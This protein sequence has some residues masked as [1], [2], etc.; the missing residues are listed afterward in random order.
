M[1]RDGSKAKDAS[2]GRGFA[3]SKLAFEGHLGTFDDGR[4]KKRGRGARWVEL[5]R[6]C[7]GNAGNVSVPLTLV[8]I[9]TNRLTMSSSTSPEK[10][11]KKS[12][13]AVPSTT[14]RSSSAPA[15]SVA[16]REYD[17]LM[18]TIFAFLIIVATLGVF[19]AWTGYS[20]RYAQVTEGWHLGQTKLI[21]VTVVTEDKA[22]LACSSDVILD[23][24][25]HCGFRANSQPFEASTQDDS[26]V[27]SPYNTVKNELFLAAGL[28]TSPALRGRLPTERFTVAC[29]YKI[30]G[31]LKS[32]GLRW[33]ANAG[34]EPVKQSVTVGTLTDCVIPK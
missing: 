15:K 1:G 24:N 6:K 17:L 7:P 16:P 4:L 28:W 14:A 18:K 20:N 2:L 22:R 30:T 25:I 32:V 21:E 3:T 19:F 27:L 31:V 33:A 29:N 10:L 8:L 5:R 23:G 26:H 11:S 13:A 12:D 34:F 9:S